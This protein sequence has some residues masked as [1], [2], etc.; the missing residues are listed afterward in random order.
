[1]AQFQSKDKKTTKRKTKT[2]DQLH[3]VS[4]VW[5][6]FG[7]FWGAVV[8]FF[9]MLSMGWLG[10]MPSFEELENP[11][12]N[13]ATEVISD[14]GEVL[15]FIGVQNRSNVDFDEISP[16]LVNALIATEDVRFYKHSGIDPRSLIRVLVKTL[17]GRRN[18]PRTSSHA[19][20][21][22]NWA[23]YIPSSKNG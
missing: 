11:K 18:W 6:V 2:G 16:N 12:S 7:F 20:R 13:L 1:M 9:F 15:G 4:V 8:L 23:S 17:V 14:N 5:K 22:A 10:F 3:Y 21:K 19:R